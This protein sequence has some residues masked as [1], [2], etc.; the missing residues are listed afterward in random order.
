VSHW[1]S[2]AAAASVAN[3]SPDGLLRSA[4]A[5]AADGEPDTVCKKTCATAQKYVIKSRFGKLKNR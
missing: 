1:C 4:G 5:G 2:A 3:E